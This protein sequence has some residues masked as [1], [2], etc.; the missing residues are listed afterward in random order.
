VDNVDSEMTR[1]KPT[2]GE[3]APLLHHTGCNGLRLSTLAETGVHRGG[4]EVA[5]AVSVD[6]VRS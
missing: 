4:C 6:D 2:I 1:E 5:L 3:R